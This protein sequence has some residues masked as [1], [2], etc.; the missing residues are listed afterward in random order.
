MPLLTTDIGFHPWYLSELPDAMREEAEDLIEKQRA[1]LSAL[2]ASPEV[3]QYYV[4]M[5]FLTSNRVTGTLPALV[6][7]AELRATRFVHATLRERAIQ[8][9]ESLETEFKDAGLVLHIDDEPD[10]F[11]VARGEH[12]I[13]L[14]E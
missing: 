12:D 14:K 3:A 1:A 11:D 10:R 8:M 7:L 13:V 2:S 9:A 6:Y 5:G 4:A